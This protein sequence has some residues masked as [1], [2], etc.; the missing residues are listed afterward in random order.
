MSNKPRMLKGDRVLDFTQFVAGRPA[1]GCSVKWV[2][3]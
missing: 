2:R 3:R 1:P